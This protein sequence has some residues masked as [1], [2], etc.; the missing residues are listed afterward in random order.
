VYASIAHHAEELGAKVIAI[1][2]ISDHVHLLVRLRP[3]IS[4]A[5][6]IGRVKG[7]SSHYIT[8]L[9]RSPEPFKWQGGYGAF[10]VSK[11]NVPAVR[12]YVLDQEVRHGTRTTHPALERTE[13]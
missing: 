7:A 4:I 3:T 11:R 5:E 2:G 8:H 1:G 9:L 13:E 10:S 12:D 6:F